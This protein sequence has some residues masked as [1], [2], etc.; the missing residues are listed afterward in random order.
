MSIELVLSLIACTIHVI[1]DHPWILLPIAV[2]VLMAAILASPAGRAS[3][4]RDPRRSFTAAERREA[5]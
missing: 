3:E 4:T 1:V 2:I 5:F